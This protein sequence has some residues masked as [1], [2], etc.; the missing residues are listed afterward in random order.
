MS[1]MSGPVKLNVAGLVTAA[2]A[3]LLQ[4]L[5]GPTHVPRSR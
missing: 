5:A 3:M 2:A 1:R 4:I